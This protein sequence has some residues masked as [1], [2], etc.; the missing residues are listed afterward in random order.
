MSDIESWIQH[1]V[2]M[3]RPLLVKDSLSDSKKIVIVGGGL[4]GMCNAYRIAQKMPDVEILLVEKSERLGGVISTWKEEEWICDLAVNAT[5]A[6]PAFW[7]LV[8]DLNLSKQFNPSRA[9]AQ[10]RWVLIGK[11]KHR[12]SPFTLFKIGPFRLLRA[13]RKAKRGGASVAQMLPHKQIAD[14]LTLGIVNNTSDNVDADF[15]M[16][17]LTEFGPSPPIKNSSL[18]KRINAT[19]PLF[20]PKKGTVASLDDGMESLISAL[21]HELESMDNV[22]IMMGESIESPQAAA[23]QFE[24]SAESI[25]W[26]AP[27]VEADRKLV[28]LSVFAVGYTNEDVSDIKYG[29][30]TLIPDESIPI[31]GILHESD[32]HHSVRAPEGHRLF[33]IMAP[34]SRWDGDEH[35]IR[36]SLQRLLSNKEP[37]LFRNLG[38]QT[39]PSYPPGYMKGL[40]KKSIDCSYVGWGVSGVSIT[41]VVDE[42]ERVAELF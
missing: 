2:E 5:R 16:P 26:T 8:K 3:R 14:A 22:T 28:K 38:V 31:S 20:T 25:L 39:I 10:S 34:H 9:R 18:K 19:Y 23:S 4:S 37:V 33:R 24:V 36:T 6:H 32:L 13:L 21:Q 41:H 17:S 27:A 35:K 11:K 15:L 1:G 42:A 40:S 30:G 12:L 7:R 29:Y